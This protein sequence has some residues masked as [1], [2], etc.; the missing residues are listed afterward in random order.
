M[1]KEL[2]LLEQ[3]KLQKNLIFG[4]MCSYRP[5]HTTRVELALRSTRPVWIG[6]FQRWFSVW[7]SLIQF[8]W[9]QFQ[10]S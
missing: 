3:V 10:W 9:F 1:R 2:E 6:C 8:D 5:F 4:H 7:V